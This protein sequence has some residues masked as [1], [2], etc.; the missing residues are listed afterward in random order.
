MQRSMET[1]RILRFVPSFIPR[2]LLSSGYL[3]LPPPPTSATSRLLTTGTTPAWGAGSREIARLR[4]LAVEDE[5]GA[6]Q[7]RPGIIAHARRYQLLRPIRQHV[8]RDV[9]QRPD[10]L[11]ARGCE[12]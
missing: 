11:P 5:H 4:P 6:E 8:T 12:V 9:R 3:L 1:C 10:R 7:D 2:P